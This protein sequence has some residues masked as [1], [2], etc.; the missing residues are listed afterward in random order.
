M[1]P[2]I[3]VVVPTHDRLSCLRQCLE[4]LAAQTFAVD[5]MEV[6]VVADG[7]SDGTEAA[8][9]RIEVPFDL[10]VITQPASGAAAARNRGAEA[11]RGALLLFL[12]DDVIPSPGLV[13]AHV[14]EHL[15]SED[16]AV[17]GPCFPGWREDQSYLAAALYRFW[18]RTYEH[19]ADPE[20]RHVLSGNL[21]LPA[22]TFSRV[23]GFDPRLVGSLE[24]YELGVRLSKSG[25]ALVYAPDAAATHLETTDLAASLRRVRSGGRASVILVDVHPHLLPSTRLFRPAHL[26]RYLAFRAPW[27][28]AVLTRL[29][30]LIL[31]GAE[32]IRFRW[33]WKAVYGQLREY[34]FWRGV[35]D[36][37]GNAD[38]WSAVRLRLEQ[39]YRAAEQAGRSAAPHGTPSS[40]AAP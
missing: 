29:G 31:G 21:S 3:S 15:T 25:V 10:R 35:A 26:P 5:R 11:A 16:C 9:A 34:C 14:R 12:D 32:R 36:Q 20:R 1:K 8:L 4:A 38:Q 27:V 17:M 28:G 23:V 2:D 24:D 7:C 37:V 6:I 33:L 40:V 22:A 18:H 39:A 13:Q 19:M 30:I